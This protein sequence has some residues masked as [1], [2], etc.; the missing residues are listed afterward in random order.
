[1]NQPI[2][3][4]NNQLINHKPNILPI[5]RGH[6]YITRVYIPTKRPHCQTDI[7]SIPSHSETVNTG[8]SPEVG[9]HT[10]SPMGKTGRQWPLPNTI[11]YPQVQRKRS[12]PFLSRH[13]NR[14]HF[15]SYLGKILDTWSRARPRNNFVEARWRLSLKLCSTQA[16]NRGNAKMANHN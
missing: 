11:D 16:R 9:L 14:N 2:K 1:M 7:G 10:S 15:V 4:S 3:E 8:S 5:K 12:V 13:L 6:V